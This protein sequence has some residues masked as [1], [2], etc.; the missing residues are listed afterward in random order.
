M[1]TRENTMSLAGQ[2]A[3]EDMVE[4]EMYL[5][6]NRSSHVAYAPSWHQE[7]LRSRGNG[8]EGPMRQPRRRDR[9]CPVKRTPLKRTARWAVFGVLLL[10]LWRLVNHVPHQFFR[11]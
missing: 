11:R 2:H 3:L 1:A 10:L 4:F 7:T 5:V 8:A 6:D 9:K